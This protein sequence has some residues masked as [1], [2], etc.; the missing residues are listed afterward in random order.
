MYLAR[1][2]YG[3]LLHG[4][5]A[6][7]GRDWAAGLE[8]GGMRRIRLRVAGCIGR[9]INILVFFD[10]LRPLANGALAPDHLVALIRILNIETAPRFLRTRVSARFNNTNGV[11]AQQLPS[12]T[13]NNEAS[14]QVP[15]FY[16]SWHGLE[17][18]R[19]CSGPQ[20]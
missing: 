17:F 19:T 16:A 3:L 8:T 4:C 6:A 13:Y 9:H 14:M 5:M 11:L 10:D 1:L 2:G 20:T 18:F 12:S 15:E 7:Y